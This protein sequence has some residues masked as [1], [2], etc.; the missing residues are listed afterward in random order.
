[1]VNTEMRLI[2]F[3]AVKGGEALYSQ[4]KEHRELIVAQLMNS[5][6]KNS[7]LNWRKWGKPLDHSDQ[8][9]SVAQS[10]LTLCDPMDRSMPGLPVHHQL[11]TLLKLMSIESL[12]PSNHL[13]LCHPLLLLLPIPPS[14]SLFQWVNSSH[15]VAKVLEFQLQHQSFQLIFR[16]DFL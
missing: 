4:Q 16:T 6:F 11:L 8:I 10:C 5:L 15:E 2:I 7:D 13:M 1:M 14:I 12:M 3:F 9:R